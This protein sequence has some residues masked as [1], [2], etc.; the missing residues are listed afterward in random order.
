VKALATIILAIA[1]SSAFGTPQ[2]DALAKAQS[3]DFKPYWLEETF[4]KTPEQA[5]EAWTPL[6]ELSKLPYPRIG[7]KIGTRTSWGTA[8]KINR[9]ITATKVHEQHVFSDGYL[10]FTN[11]KLTAIQD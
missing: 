6:C 8:K 10:Y 1:S 4:L 7:M 5:I 9:T 11:G 3:G 2:C